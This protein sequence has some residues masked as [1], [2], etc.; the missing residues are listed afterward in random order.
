MIDIAT[1][2]SIEPPTAWT[3][4]NAIS[5]PRLGARLHSNEPRVKSTS[6]AW[7]IR[8]RPRRSP[9]A[10]ARISRLASTSVYASSTHCS[11]DTCA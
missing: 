10:P 6:P 5:Q 9:V 4:R 1:G 3:I 2:L 11:P 8:R 7:K